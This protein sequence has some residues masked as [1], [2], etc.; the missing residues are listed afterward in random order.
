MSPLAFRSGI[1]SIPHPEKADK[2]GEDAFFVQ[3]T[4][5]GVF[6]GVGGWASIGVDAGLYSK[7]LA[8]L[9]AA[10][11]DRQGS[12]AVVDA[13]KSAKDN[14]RAIGSS[15]AC[16][17]GLNDDKLV[18]VNLGDSGL[19]VIRN[20]NVVYRTCEQQHYFNCPYQ[21][22]TDSLDTVEVGHPIDFKVQ[23]GDWI[24]MGTDGLW[25]N[26]FPDKIVEIVVRNHDQKPDS[27]PKVENNDSTKRSNDASSD[28]GSV[29]SD[30]STTDT[31]AEDAQLIA[32]ELA[33]A[34]VAVAHD[35]RSSS[36]FAVNAQ[37]A[38]HLFL[39]GK[40]DDIT[41]IA[42]M[43]MDVNQDKANVQ[44]SVEDVSGQSDFQ[45]VSE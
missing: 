31:R 21:I 42:A 35:E 27:Q 29:L 6:D 25:D 4:A 3:R 22:G 10:Y 24:I 44:A 2:G 45:S 36:P 26:V 12:A 38:G 41:I 18:G 15:T 13:L 14:N 39:G 37:N 8:R 11:V 34:A 17:I 33:R 1:A 20:G 40:V 30:C 9:T 19:I 7:E 32:I 28:G 43:V 16:V 5:I 23:H